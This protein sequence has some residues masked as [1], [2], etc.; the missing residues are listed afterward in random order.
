MIRSTKGK[1]ILDV[2]N[3]RPGKGFPVGIFERASDMLTAI[4]AATLV[5][6]LR[7]PPGNQLEK[8]K[9]DRAGQYSVRI[10]RQWRYCFE[11]GPDGP[12]NVELVDYH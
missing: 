10:N 7:F 6:D 1:L 5:D 2:L 4:E 3:G 12:E 11:W 8:L 9:G